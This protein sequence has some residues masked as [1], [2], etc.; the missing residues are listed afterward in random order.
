MMR[1]S[2]KIKWNRTVDGVRN[3]IHRLVVIDQRNVWRSISCNLKKKQHLL[4]TLKIE[5]F[6]KF[7]DR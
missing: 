5:R 1:R 6:V 3:F 2:E 4:K 7:A